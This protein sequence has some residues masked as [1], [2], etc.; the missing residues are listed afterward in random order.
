[1]KILILGSRERYAAYMPEMPFLR[2][3]ELVYCDPDIGEAALLATAGDADVLFVGSLTPVPASLIGGMP[4]LKMIHCE[5]VGCEHIDLA[6]A[7]ERGVYVC[8][9]RGCNAGAVAEQ[10]VMLVLMLLR[11][12]LQGDRMVRAGQQAEGRDRAMARGLPELSHCRVGLVGFGDTG[13]ATAERLAPFGCEVFYTSRRRQD[14][15]EEADYGVTY[16]TMAELLATCDVV[17]LH[18]AVNN[19]TRGMVNGDFLSR[20]KRSAFLINTA[21]GELVDNAALRLALT[22]DRLAGAG[23]DTL[24]PEPVP[25]DH[26]LVDLPAPVCDRVVLSPHVGGIT[27]SS[28]CRAHLHMWRNVERVVNGHRPDH[29]VNGW[30]LP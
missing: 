7:R 24:W 17:S 27:R 13:K 26:P 22:E 5:G 19:E 8:N 18:C 1:M 20:M 29:I 2:Q 12:A 10:T 30:E 6:A 21:G 15:R 4:K 28:F 16:L 25:A 23:L 3:Q 9:N 11:G 14:R